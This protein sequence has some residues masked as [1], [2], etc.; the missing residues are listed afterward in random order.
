MA[1]RASNATLLAPFT[2]RTSFR[3]VAKE[4]LSAPPL[5]VGAVEPPVDGAVVGGGVVLVGKTD[6]PPPVV[7]PPHAESAKSAKIGVNCFIVCS[8]PMA[9]DLGG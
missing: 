6:A 3:S 7:A 5:V 2:R 8:L 1:N 9:E 4:A